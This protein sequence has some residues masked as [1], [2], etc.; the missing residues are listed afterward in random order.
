MAGMVA[1]P[2]LYY[3]TFALNTHSG[4][5]VTGS[6]NPPEYN[7]LKTM[8]T[9]DARRRCDTER[10]GASNT[11]T[12][13]GSGGYR[14]HDIRGRISR[15]SSATKLARTV[16]IAVDCGNGVA[17]LCPSSTA[18]SVAMCMVFATWTAV[19]QIIILILQPKNL[20]D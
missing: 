14:T 13:H 2:M 19:F 7:G 1:T 17:A 11:A 6:H 8:L 12:L 9:G 4:V 16:S 18:A 3:A 5:M 15:A 10:A 20:Q